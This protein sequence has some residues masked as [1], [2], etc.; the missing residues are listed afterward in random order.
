MSTAFTDEQLAAF[1]AGTMTD[2]ALIDAIAAA[3]DADPALAARA[4]ALADGETDTAAAVRAAFAP[5]LAAAVP[6]HLTRIIPA[7]ASAAVVD[8]AAACAAK[9]THRLPSPRL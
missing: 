9:A 4:E 8:L 7:P 6:E 1:I 2:E 5:V 3:I